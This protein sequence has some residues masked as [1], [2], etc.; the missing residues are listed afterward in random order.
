LRFIPDVHH[1]IEEKKKSCK[2]VQLTDTGL[3]W[4]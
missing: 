4:D 3:T 2:I 1:R